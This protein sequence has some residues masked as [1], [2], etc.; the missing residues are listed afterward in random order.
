[1][2]RQIAS[3]TMWLGDS[4]ATITVDCV[5]IYTVDETG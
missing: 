2:L 4:G 1:V 5:V 3:I